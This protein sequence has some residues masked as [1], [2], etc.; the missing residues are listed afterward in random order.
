MPTPP[1]GKL[2]KRDLRSAFI[3]E[4]GDFTLWLAE[5]ANL[6][7][8]ADSL[9][10]DELEL[11]AT[12]KDIGP[13]RADI[14]CKDT[15]NGHW[16]LIENQLSRTDHGHL[17]QLLTYAA[18][19]QAVT[20][21]WIAAPFTEEHRAALDWLNDVT[22]ERVRFFGV[23]IELWQIGD[24][25]PAPRF[26]VVSKP[27][28]WAK[29]VSMAAAGA[30]DTLTETKKLQ[31]E[32]WTEFRRYMEDHPGNVRPTKPLPQSWMA[33]SAG[34]A[35]FTTLTTI[36]IQGNWISAWLSIS[37]PKA[38]PFFYL[39]HEEKEAIEEEFGEKLDWRERP[40]RIESQVALV[41]EPADP[42]DRHDW[43]RQHA[44]LRDRL[45][46]FRAV[47]RPRVRWPSPR[48]LLSWSKTDHRRTIRS[49]PNRCFARTLRFGPLN[50]PPC[51]AQVRRACGAGCDAR[52]G[53][54]DGA[55]VPVLPTFKGALDQSA[56]VATLRNCGTYS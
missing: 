18:G 51:R 25:P 41:L 1:L 5:E 30:S 32:Y 37:G 43:P 23:E 42:S 54:H 35:D 26:N 21:V 31:L 44:W 34:R 6:A 36:N 53:L 10:I 8:L 56:A 50:T 3:S 45:E 49:A 29:S 55:H 52:T 16:V 12:E 11:E 24:S 48:A 39:L 28:E 20:I 22:D 38:K 19:L 14:L 17:G 9:G 13:F 27:N 46:R 40:E 2:E 33:F 4:P 7:Q 15:G 47:F